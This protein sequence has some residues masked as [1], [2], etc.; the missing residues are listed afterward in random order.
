MIFARK[1]WK[2]LVALKDGRVVSDTLH[3]ALAGDAHVV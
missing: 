2:L 3:T 1:V